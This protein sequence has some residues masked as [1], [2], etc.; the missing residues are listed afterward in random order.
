MRSRKAGTT[1]KMNMMANSYE[2]MKEC[3]ERPPAVLELSRFDLYRDLFFL[4]NLGSIRV[5]KPQ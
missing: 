4:S 1:I 5:L 2:A 3:C